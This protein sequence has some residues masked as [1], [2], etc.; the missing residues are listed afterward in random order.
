VPEANGLEFTQGF[1]PDTLG[2]DR[3][4]SGFFFVHYCSPVSGAIYGRG[5]PPG[6]SVGRGYQAA[7][8]RA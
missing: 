4:L 7:E 8:K 1:D 2:Q 3:N 5:V 6:K